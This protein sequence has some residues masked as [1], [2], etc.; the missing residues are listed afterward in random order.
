MFNIKY[1]RKYIS[2]EQLIKRKEIP[3]K[4]NI[5]DEANNYVF[6]SFFVDKN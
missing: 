2:D 3:E 1:M 4:V 6:A 5:K